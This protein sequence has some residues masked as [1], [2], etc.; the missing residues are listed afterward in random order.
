MSI[1]DRKQR[2]IH[3]RIHYGIGSY[4]S[5]SFERHALEGISARE[6]INR[7]INS[8]Q[9]HPSAQRTAS[10]LRD[11]LRCQREIDVELSRAAS[12]REALEGTPIALS[13]VVVEKSRADAK[14]EKSADD[15]TINLAVSEQYRGGRC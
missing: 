4:C 9:P 12:W 11:A 13:D 14:S 10:V 1:R 6:L 3:A 2:R 15:E 5:S 7:V 8:P